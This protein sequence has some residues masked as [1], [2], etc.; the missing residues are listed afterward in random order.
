MVTK[1]L[2]DILFKVDLCPVYTV[3]KKK[4]EL[5][6]GY[7]VTNL[8]E[9]KIL[10]T[11]SD[12][13]ELTTNQDMIDTAKEMYPEITFDY[14]HFDNNKSYF[15]IYFLHKSKLTGLWQWGVELINAYDCKTAPK[16]NVCF[17][18]IKFNYYLYTNIHTKG[19]W[20]Y[21]EVLEAFEEYKDLHD[22]VNSYQRARVPTYANQLVST[23]VLLGIEVW[24]QKSHHLARNWVAEAITHFVRKHKES[25]INGTNT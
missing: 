22:S 12:R 15:H 8:D 25:K 23:D 16:I 1:D 21:T 5:F 6:A 18:H 17:K 4:P 20:A 19:D 24:R 10:K 3:I 13:Y 2:Q 11:V 9:N 7:A 14:A